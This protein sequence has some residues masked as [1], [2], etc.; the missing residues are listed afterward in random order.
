MNSPQ[1]QGQRKQKERK[2]T[3]KIMSITGMGQLGPRRDNYL[4]TLPRR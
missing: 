1:L 2:Q 3:G 4:P